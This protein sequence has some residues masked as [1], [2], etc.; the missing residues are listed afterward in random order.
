[1][2]FVPY[3]IGTMNGAHVSYQLNFLSY[4]VLLP[5]IDTVF[6]I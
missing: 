6:C 5:Q 4:L 2:N 1:M 3:L